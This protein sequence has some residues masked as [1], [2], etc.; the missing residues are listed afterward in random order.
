MKFIRIVSLNSKQRQETLR[1]CKEDSLQ[2]QQQ[3][4][5][6]NLENFVMQNFFSV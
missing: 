1:N 2:D 4:Y 6:I 5:D 3:T